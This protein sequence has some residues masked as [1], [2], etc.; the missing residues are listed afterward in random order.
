MIFLG[1]A[2]QWHHRPLA[3]EIVHRAR[4]AGLAGATVLRGIEG[5]GASA[6]VHT[7]RLIGLSD[8]LPVV[9]VLVDTAERIDAFLPALDELAPHGLVIRDEVHV[10]RSAGG[11]NSGPGPQ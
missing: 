9:V 1:E 11:Q 4:D 6:R 5:Y 3:T 8:D 7:A 10:V 2:D